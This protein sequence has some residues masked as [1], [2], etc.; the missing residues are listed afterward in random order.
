MTLTSETVRVDHNGDGSTTSFAVTFVFWDADDLDVLRRDAAGTETTWAR[1]TQYTV[2]GGN[3]ST[4]TVEV[5]TT[6]TD[7][8]PALGETLTIVSAL[9]T[10]QDTALPAIPTVSIEEQMDKI[11]RMI[12]ENEEALGRSLRF[13]RSDSA[14]LSA[15]IPGSASRASKLL[16]FDADGEPAVTAVSAFM[17]TMLDDTTAATARKTLSTHVPVVHPTNAGAFKTGED[18]IF[19]NENVHLNGVD[20]F[21][22]TSNDPSLVPAIWTVTGSVTVGQRTGLRV[23]I[24]SVN[25]DFDYTAQTGDTLADIGDEISKLLVASYNAGTISD[26]VYPWPNATAGPH[27][28]QVFW[29]NTV[30]IADNSE[31]GAT[32][33]LSVTQNGNFLDTGPVINLRRIVSG[34]TPVE[35][36]TVGSFNAVGRDDAGGNQGYAGLICA[37][38]DP[39]AADPIGQ[40]IITTSTAGG[41][42]PRFIV[43]RGAMMG[44]TTGGIPRDPGAGFL[45]APEGIQVGNTAGAHAAPG[46]VQAFDDA[47]SQ[48]G[49]YIGGNFSGSAWIWGRDNTTTGDWVLG[50]LANA[51]DATPT[52]QMRVTTNGEATLPNQPSFMA[53]NS[54]DD[55][56][57][58][59]NGTAATVD[60]DTE[61]FDRG[62]NFAADTFTA[63]VNG[64][65][66]FQTN[67]VVRGLTTSHTQALLEIVTSNE[68]IRLAEIDIGAIRDSTNVATIGGAATVLMD[69][70]DTATVRLTISG[71]GSDDADIGGATGPRTYFSGALIA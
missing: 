66:A 52:N 45:L 59:G 41:A 56:N 33:T 38:E 67:V 42:L 68:T 19:A 47:V 26:E 6:P 10:T 12:Q 2:T 62:T 36:D 21:Q 71:S 13:P 1:G 24:N 5:A 50:D 69:A 31:G 23:T 29:N 61:I 34:R 43:S 58:T 16:S 11:V 32:A 30:V 8:T 7:Y 54:A 9:T 27:A 4:G 28:L 25:H 60:F 14:T 63:P 15:E 37:I 35:G 70:S 22:L 57:V 44:T 51:A 39:S 49:Q 46:V 40:W 55:N 64:I 65:Y 18:Y 53:Y 17:A 3:G 48:Y 20:S